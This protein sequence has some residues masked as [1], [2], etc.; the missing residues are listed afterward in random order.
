MFLSWFL[1]EQPR[2]SPCCLNSLICHASCISLT[3]SFCD[4][5]ASLVYPTRPNDGVGRS[6]QSTSLVSVL[7][8]PSASTFFSKVR[9]KLGAGPKAKSASF[10]SGIPLTDSGFH[11]GTH[12]SDSS[13]SVA[14]GAQ[15]SSRFV[16]AHGMRSLSTDALP[17]RMSANGN[18]LK[19]RESGS[20]DDQ[21]TVS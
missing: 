21:C 11:E 4:L 10:V 8:S 20:K 17:L 19:R 3:A 2:L 6:L 1:G 9:P 7:P 15:K 16:K 13:G 14:N 12:R 18:K 5:R